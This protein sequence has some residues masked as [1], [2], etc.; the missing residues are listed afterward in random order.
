MPKT[1]PLF[2]IARKTLL[3]KATV[4]VNDKRY[5]RETTQEQQIAAIIAPVAEDLG[6]HLVRVKILP[7]NGCT[8]QIMAED[9]SGKFSIGNCER[10]SHEISPILDLNEP[11]DRAYHLE[12]SSP[13]ID[14]PL[15]RA[16]D[17][18]RWA[19]H[20]AR[21]EL[22]DMIK[23]RKRFRGQIEGADEQNVTIC[24]PD[25]PE[26]ADPVHILPLANIAEAK[27]ILTDS[28][29]EAA[30]LEQENDPALDDDDIETIKDNSKET[31]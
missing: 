5:I 27:L 29:L 30:R 10:L 4:K 24:L 31:D 17:F 2:F 16:R 22:R 8:L 23:G 15:V 25:V 3:Q 26:G 1:A 20:E 9:D 7:D 11:I 18:A 28:L 12:V 19:G 6:F 14:R 13:G 21:I